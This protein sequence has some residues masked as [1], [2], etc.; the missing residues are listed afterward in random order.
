MKDIKELSE[1]G[2]LLRRAFLMNS[3]ERNFLYS[4][5]PNVRKNY[6]IIKYGK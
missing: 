5:Q 6:F 1:K 2:K 4:K 3:E